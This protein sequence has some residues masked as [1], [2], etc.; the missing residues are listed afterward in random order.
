[1]DLPAGK[2][3]QPHTEGGDKADCD[4]L[5]THAS[6]LHMGTY[7]E[8]IQQGHLPPTNDRVMVE[9]SDIFIWG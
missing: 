9:K 1:M 4:I 5:P 6:N 3:D 2:K 7:R 8:N